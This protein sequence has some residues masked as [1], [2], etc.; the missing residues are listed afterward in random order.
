MSP[1][2]NQYVLG[3]A[4]CIPS[5]CQVA[6]SMVLVVNHP[7]LKLLKLGK[8][9]VRA[10]HTDLSSLLTSEELEEENILF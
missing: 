7:H 5:M 9:R 6:N 3:D 4:P 8:E 10:C 2:A 1:L